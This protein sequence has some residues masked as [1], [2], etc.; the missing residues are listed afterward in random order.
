MAHGNDLL[1]M[2]R[3]DAA[4]RRGDNNQNRDDT[5]SHEAST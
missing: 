1:R 4:K 2:D 3:D 5:R